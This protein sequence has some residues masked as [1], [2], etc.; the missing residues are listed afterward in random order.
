MQSDLR[1][2]R[3]ELV[4][5]F[6]NDSRFSKY[7]LEITVDCDVPFDDGSP[8]QE[9]LIEIVNNDLEVE[10]KGIFAGQ[11]VHP[12]VN[13][14]YATEGIYP[15]LVLNNNIPEFYYVFNFRQASITNLQTWENNSE[16]ET[17]ESIIEGEFLSAYRI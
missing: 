11:K 2:L 13:I 4:K 14:M 6:E 5:F 8:R 1:A 17:I 15:Q 10:L 3:R 16:D 12:S 7:N 9:L